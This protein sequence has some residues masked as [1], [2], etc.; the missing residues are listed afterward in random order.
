MLLVK[1]HSVIFV[2]TSYKYFQYLLIY[3]NNNSISPTHRDHPATLQLH[4]HEDASLEV[5]VTT[6]LGKEKLQ[7]TETRHPKDFTVAAN[8]ERRKQNT[9]H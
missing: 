1:K 4:N 7:S 5:S 8:G 6:E 9:V 3:L 2:F